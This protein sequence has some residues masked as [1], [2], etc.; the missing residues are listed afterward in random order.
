MFSFELLDFVRLEVSFILQIRPRREGV[1]FHSGAVQFTS[2]IF[3]LNLTAHNLC[4][5]FVSTLQMRLRQQ[6]CL[7]LMQ[8]AASCRT[9]GERILHT[10][11]EVQG[12]R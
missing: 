8:T 10:V 7:E 9:R 1:S 2:D 11:F 12:Q 6:S 4:Q 3:L 5:I